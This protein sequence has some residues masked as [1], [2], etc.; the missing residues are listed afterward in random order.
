MRF[1]LHCY[2]C[3]GGKLHFVHNL[4]SC[5]LGQLLDARPAHCRYAVVVGAPYH[6]VWVIDM[7]LVVPDDFSALRL[8]SQDIYPDLDTAIAA[9][10]L[11]MS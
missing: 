3:D 5:T 10:I 9:T 2:V 1:V 4:G 11:K 8:S 7:Y 6:A